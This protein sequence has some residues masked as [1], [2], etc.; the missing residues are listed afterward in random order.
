MECE[1]GTVRLR[2]LYRKH[3]RLC[4][5]DYNIQ[6]ETSWSVIGT[7]WDCETTTIIQETS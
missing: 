6:L 2:L 3:H 4:D 7:G 1:V 5:Y